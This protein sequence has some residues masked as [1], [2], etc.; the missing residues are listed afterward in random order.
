[1]IIKKEISFH[2]QLRIIEIYNN[3]ISEKEYN[4]KKTKQSN[5]NILKEKYQTSKTWI[6][7]KN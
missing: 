6:D 5:L 3:M 4:N 7:K 2:N 1:M